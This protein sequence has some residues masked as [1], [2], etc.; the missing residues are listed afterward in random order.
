MAVTQTII[1][2]DNSGNTHT[3]VDAL[4]TQLSADVSGMDA[5]VTLIESCTA[6][7]TLVNTSELSEAGTGVSI[8]RVWDDACWVD[9][10][11]LDGVDAS[12][13]ADAGWTVESSDDS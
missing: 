3:S 2:T 6:D 5:S 4:M 8:T 12:A 7:G 13:F 1:I 11:A 9:F 10:S